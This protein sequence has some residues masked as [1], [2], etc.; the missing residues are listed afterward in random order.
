[1]LCKKPEGLKIL[2]LRKLISFA[3]FL[4][5]AETDMKFVEYNNR[6]QLPFLYFETTL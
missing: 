3:E 2:T 4:E 5:I 6:P 1:M